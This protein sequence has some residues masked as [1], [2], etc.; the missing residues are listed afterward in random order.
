[1]N[2]ATLIG[3]VGKDPESRNLRDDEKVV[4]FSLATEE[5]WRDKATGERKSKTEWHNIVIFNQGL[6]KVASQYVLKGSRLCVEGK[7]TTRKW[8]DKDGNDRYTTEIVLDKFGGYL[9]L[10][11]DKN[12]GSGERQSSSGSSSKPAASSNRSADLDD[13]IPF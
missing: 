10:L 2:K 12:D 1:M 8:Q 11:G 9:E 4:S 3:R 13:D 5:S 6:G 7:I